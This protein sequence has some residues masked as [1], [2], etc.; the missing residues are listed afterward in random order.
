ML[1]NPALVQYY[2]SFCIVTNEE[3]N[4]NFK[5]DD[6]VE[7]GI[8]HVE[9]IAINAT[10]KIDMKSALKGQPQEEEE[11]DGCYNDGQVQPRG[12]LEVRIIELSIE[13]LPKVT[14]WMHNEPV[15]GFNMSLNFRPDHLS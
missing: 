2:F 11:R 8:I 10:C 9:A 14:E 12:N 13:S 4:N 7:D 1:G 5:E 6:S 3:C 15:F